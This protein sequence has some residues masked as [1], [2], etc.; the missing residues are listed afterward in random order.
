MPARHAI[1]RIVRSLDPAYVVLI[2]GPTWPGPAWNAMLSRSIRRSSPIG[3]SPAG[4]PRRL[5]PA[6]AGGRRRPPGPVGPQRL[7][8]GADL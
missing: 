7:A 2:S 1:G 5:R 6:G 4:V 3:V 8:D